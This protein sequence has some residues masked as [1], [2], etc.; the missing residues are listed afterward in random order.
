M[1]YLYNTFFLLKSFWPFIWVRDLTCVSK[2]IQKENVTFNF[3]Y[4]NKIADFTYDISKGVKR[5][6]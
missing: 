6:N 4:F 2:K 5:T 3:Y 1:Y